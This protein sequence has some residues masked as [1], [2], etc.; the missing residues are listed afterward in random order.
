MCDKCEA[1]YLLTEADTGVWHRSHSYKCRNKACLARIIP[2]FCV[3]CVEV[4][5]KYGDFACC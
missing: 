3:E 2:Y 1:V 5:K 4:R